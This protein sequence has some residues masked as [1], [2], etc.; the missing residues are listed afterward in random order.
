VLRPALLADA[1]ELALLGERLWRATYT[2][3]IPASNLERHLTQTFGPS[4]QT[5]ELTDPACLTLVLEERA[6]LLAYTL[7]K[8]GAPGAGNA[9][10]GF[11]N[12]LEIARFYVDPSL[13]GTGAA[14]TLMAAVLGHAATAGHDGVWLQ[15]WEQNPRG[16]RFYAKAG[17]TDAGETT[18]RVGDQI[19]RDRLMVR[20]T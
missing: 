18:F 13:H 7:L 8:A 10:A 17:F 6:C 4:Q 12:A 3:L 1:Q 15:V 20:R 9:P 14:Q 19:D 11:A 16:I 2:G 5:V